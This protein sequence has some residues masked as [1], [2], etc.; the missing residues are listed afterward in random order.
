[1][2]EQL[3][4]ISK[5]RTYQNE[6]S[7]NKTSCRSC[8]ANLD[9]KQKCLVCGEPI[10]WHCSYCLAIYDSTHKHS[11]NIVSL[12]PKSIIGKVSEVEAC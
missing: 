6:S 3:E 2:P 4:H 10:V 11:S 1:M 7:Y 8:G 9:V 12:K 5:G